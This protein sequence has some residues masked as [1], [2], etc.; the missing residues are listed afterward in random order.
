MKKNLIIL[1]SFTTI[2]LSGCFDSNN[3]TS[4]I[5]QENL[6]STEQ[7]FNNQLDETQYIKDLEIFLSYNILSIQEDK[8][9]TSDFSISATFDKDSSVQWW[10]DLSQKKYSKTYDNEKR[11]IEFNLIANWTTGSLEPFEIS[12]SVTL[13]YQDD[14][15]YANLHKLGVFMW[16]WNMVAKMYTLLWD[17]LIDNRVNLEVHSWWI[18]SVD[19]RENDKIP[20]LL[21][22]IKNVI[23]TEDIQTSP[24]FLWNTAE[25]IDTINSYINLWISTNE[26]KLIN[27]EIT[28][29]ELTDKTIQKIFTWTFQWKE[30]AFDLSFTASQ[31]WLDIDIYN[32]KTY[33]ED[34]SDYRDNELKLIF[35]IK[36]NKKSEYSIKFELINSQQKVANLEWNIEFMDTVKFSSNFILEPLEIISWQK[37]SWKLEWTINKQSWNI[38][39]ELPELSW[40]ILSLSELLSS[41]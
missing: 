38:N 27:Q 15:M 6:S 41:L 30:S 1:L 36:E 35:S 28:Y 4:K 25:L 11:D 40:N 33:D 3:Q 20:Y 21:W 39:E 13:L 31:K 24:N 2:L 12:W 37:I 32:I 18:I 22:T 23:K 14:E 16:E 19:E 29:F 7:T 10:F 26:L 17:L 9:F 8:P 34:I 5:T